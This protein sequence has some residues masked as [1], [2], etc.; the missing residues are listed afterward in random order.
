MDLI[1]ANDQP[2]AQADLGNFLEF[3][4]R[5][6]PADGIVRIAKDKEPRPLGNRLLKSLEVD[7]VCVSLAHE[8]RIY[9]HATMLH[10]ISQKVEI[11]GRLRQHR[12]SGPGKSLEG[13]VEA[14]YD[15]GEKENLFL[16][17][18]PLVNCFRPVLQSAS[19]ILCGSCVSEDSMVDPLAQRTNDGL[20]GAEIHVRNP[21]RN[22]IIRICAPF[23]GVGASPV[24]NLV[25]TIFHRYSCG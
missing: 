6:D 18:L 24:H 16:M 9:K 1:R 2:V 20:R 25:K 10:G 17:D 15:P 8:R 4:P 14:G 12:L 13:D 5:V 21:H 23:D 7:L 22:Y 3:S 11:N 19:Q